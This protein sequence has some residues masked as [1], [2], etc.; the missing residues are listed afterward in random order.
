[1]R[2]LLVVLLLVSLAGCSLF[3]RKLAPPSVEKLEADR[4][5][6]EFVLPKWSTYV[7]RDDL[8]TQS[9]RQGRI[10]AASAWVFAVNAGMR[11]QSLP[12]IVIA[13]PDFSIPTE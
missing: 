1:M 10:D 11:A 3:S 5:F 13:F 2:Q 7:S 9:Q 12:E 6:A 8:L 4:A